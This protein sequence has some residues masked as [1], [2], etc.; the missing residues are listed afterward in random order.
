MC[1][2]EFAKSLDRAVFPGLQG[3]PLMHVIAAKAIALGMAQTD[4]FIERQ[5]R[6]VS[7]CQALADGSR[8]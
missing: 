1:D 2:E 7:N 3:G 8:G 5:Q 6:T 4:E